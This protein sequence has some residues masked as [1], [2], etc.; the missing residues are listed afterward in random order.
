MMENLKIITL[1]TNGLRLSS[2][3]R[4]LF[5]KLRKT[6][7]DLIL[8]QEIHSTLNDETVWLT[9]WG[10]KGI[11][12]HGRS[13]SRGICIL[14]QRDTNLSID[15][16]IRDDDGRSLILQLSREDE[17]LS[18]VNLYAPVTSEPNNQLAFLNNIQRILSGL[19]IQNLII[20]G[21]LNVQMDSAHTM[22]TPTH[23]TTMPTR[24][25]YL[26]H[27]HAL[28][29]E[30]DLVDVWKRKNPNSNQGTFHRNMYSSRLDYIF[31]PSHLL[32]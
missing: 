1:N 4:A 10:G 22:T 15:R 12:C 25:D 16:I 20:G 28:L 23:H 27:I 8:L 13:N 14:L 9:E 5:L 17:H 29:E 18:L 31:A 24:D 32:P 11:F 3:R 6:K 21:D 30:Y 19:E 26:S 7:G 2:K